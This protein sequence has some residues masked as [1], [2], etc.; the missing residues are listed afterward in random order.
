M[1]KEING[2]TILIQPGQFPVLLKPDDRSI[3]GMLMGN[4]TYC[5]PGKLQSNERFQLTTEERN[6]RKQ[7]KKVAVFTNKVIVK[8]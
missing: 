7:M 8:T 6:Q 4:R 2:K 1:I 3:D 5:R